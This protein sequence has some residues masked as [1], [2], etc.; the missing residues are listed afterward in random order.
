VP[1]PERDSARSFYLGPWR[2]DIVR[3]SGVR[4]PVSMAAL[5]RLAAAALSAAS[6]PRPAS[7]ALTL[8]GDDE[9]ALLNRR[10]MGKAGPTDVLSFPLLTPGFALPPGQRV[11][12]GD[13]IVS[14]DR[15]RAQAITGRGGQTGD[16]A[17][18]AADELR[19]LVAHGVLHVCGHDHTVPAERDR[20]RALERRVLEATAR[21]SA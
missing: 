10:H 9:L 5:A 2:I 17:G 19:L 11:H 6:A 8:S 3:R 1:E 18:S 20:M 14:V 7:I 16:V 15:A 12:L 21:R 13:V 4:S